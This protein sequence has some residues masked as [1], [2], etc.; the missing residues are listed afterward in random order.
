LW[1]SLDKTSQ[2][3]RNFGGLRPPERQAE[4]RE[5]GRCKP[6]GDLLVIGR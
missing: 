3:Q 1:A 4:L 5:I 6:E 2:G